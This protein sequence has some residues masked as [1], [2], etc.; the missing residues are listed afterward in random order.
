MSDLLSKGK[1]PLPVDREAVR[2]DW[3]ERGYDCRPF[4]D[5]PGRE[6]RDFVHA[7]NELVTVQKGGLNSPLGRMC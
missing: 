1:F 6:W 2:R 3:A 5:P 4:H 7:T